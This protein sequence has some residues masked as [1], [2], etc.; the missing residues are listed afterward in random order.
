MLV[1]RRYVVVVVGIVV[2]VVSVD[3]SQT[4]IVMFDLYGTKVLMLRLSIVTMLEAAWL[5]E[6]VE[7]SAGLTFTVK[8]SP[9][10]ICVAWPWDSS[11]TDGTWILQYP[12]ETVSVT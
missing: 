5:G 7:G 1:N 2:D 9:L 8:W 3:D 4:K 11:I 6:H 12:V 10:R